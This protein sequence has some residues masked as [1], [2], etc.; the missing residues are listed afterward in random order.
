[1]KSQETVKERV[2]EHYKKEHIAAQQQQTK[3]SIIWTQAYVVKK[4]KNV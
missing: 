4:D 2:V 3:S 1:M